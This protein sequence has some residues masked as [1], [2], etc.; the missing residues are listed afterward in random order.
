MLLFEFIAYLIDLH[1]EALTKYFLFPAVNRY[2]P[3]LLIQA[4]L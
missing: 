3:P 4:I 2:D 1:A